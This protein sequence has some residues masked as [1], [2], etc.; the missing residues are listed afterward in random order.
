MINEGAKPWWIDE[1][2]HL[3]VKN[4]NVISM[5][6]ENRLPNGLAHILGI[7]TVKDQFICQSIRIRAWTQSSDGGNI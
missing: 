5:Y 1:G 7:L 3:F 2:S 6:I 4:W